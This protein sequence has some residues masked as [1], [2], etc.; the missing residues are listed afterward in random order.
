MK[1]LMNQV[2]LP[3]KNE[4]YEELQAE[5]ED[6]KSKGGKKM[7]Q[8]WPYYMRSYIDDL[9]RIANLTPIKPVLIDI[10]D[11]SR[12]L[13]LNDIANYRKYKYHRIDEQTYVIKF[14]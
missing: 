13:S 14:S 5:S 7:H 6:R 2:K 4:M 10:Y 9:V 12:A 8:Q 11:E 1:I 3:T